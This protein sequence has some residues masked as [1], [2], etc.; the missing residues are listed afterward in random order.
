MN[1]TDTNSKG[2]TSVKANPI[3]AVAEKFSFFVQ[4]FMPDAIL[5]AVILAAIVFITGIAI[6]NSPFDMITYFISSMWSLLAF[7]MLACLLLVFFS[8]LTESGLFKMFFDAMLKVPK[9]ATQAIVFGIFISAVGFLINYALGLVI[10]GIYCKKISQ[11]IRGIH[12]PMLVACCYSAMVVWHGGIGGTIPLTMNTPGLYGEAALGYVLSMSETTFGPLNI[13]LVVVFLITLPLLAKIMAPPKGYPVIEADISLADV[14]EKKH[15]M[16]EH[17]TFA[18]R[19]EYSRIV[20]LAVALFF[21]VG[22]VR[23]FMRDGVLN[24]LSI[25]NMV[26][27]TFVLLLYFSDNLMDLLTKCI[28]SGPSCVPMMV[29]FPIYAGIMGMIVTSGIAAILVN[30]F[31][32]SSTPAMLPNVLNISSAVL[33]MFIPSGGGK[34]AIECPIYIK[35]ALTVCANIPNVC[36]AAAWGDAVTNLIQPFWALPLLAIAGLKIRDIMGYCVIFC[37]Y[38]L[39][40]IQLILYIFSIL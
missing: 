4:N 9:T 15:V 36:M 14:T 23:I 30:F 40:V 27:I 11:R 22:L 31:A 29:Q 28:K 7:A 2:C 32:S 3:L 21:T 24:S 12:Y 10:G 38:G 37:V 25:Y 33:N 5:F 17:P 39:I 13:T 1:G 16:P 34:W 20:S 6:G 19:L 8:A 26:L 35:T 18:Q